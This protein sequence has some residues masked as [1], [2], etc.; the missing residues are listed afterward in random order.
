VSKVENAEN[1]LSGAKQAA[2]KP[3][4]TG[5]K[6]ENHSAGAKARLLLSA[7]YGTAEVVP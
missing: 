1:H 3:Q 6:P 4:R 2:E 5:E 7:S